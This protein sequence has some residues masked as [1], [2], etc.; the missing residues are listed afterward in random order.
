[1]VEQK[2]FV[3]SLRLYFKCN[4]IDEFTKYKALLAEV[5]DRAIAN[6]KFN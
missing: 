3:S 6:I 5:S 2:K 4:V 1:M